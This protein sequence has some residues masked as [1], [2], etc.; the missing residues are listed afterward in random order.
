MPRPRPRP[1]A[2]QL[3]ASLGHEVEDCGALVDDPEDDYPEI[4]A[5][6]ARKLSEDVAAGRDS[7]ASRN[8]AMPPPLRFHSRQPCSA[9]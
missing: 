2:S 9:G 8:P 3:L 7:R 1:V 5:I 6:A 4:I